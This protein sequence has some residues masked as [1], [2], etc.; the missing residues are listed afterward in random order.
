M[1]EHSTEI[2]RDVVGFEGWYRVSNQ[3]RIKSLEK[4]VPTKD[5]LV[6]HL[7]E[8]VLKA[9]IFRPN[10]IPTYFMV[11]LWKGQGK[12]T[13]KYKYVHSLVLEAF[14]GSRP[15]GMQ[16]RHLDG[17]G[18]NNDLGNLA[19]GTVK[20]NA[21]DRMRHG[22]SGKGKPGVNFGERHGMVKRTVEE[23]L[24]I[25]EMSRQGLSSSQIAKQ[26]GAN[27]AYIRSIIRRKFWARI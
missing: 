7:K 14:S 27:P 10:G 4:H 23:I 5:G 20:E 9:W 12:G 8:R 26:F 3:G 17:N 6:K 2:W 19:W 24:R 25:R 15:K 22:T 1:C 18:F 21:G 13:G 11:S 16:C